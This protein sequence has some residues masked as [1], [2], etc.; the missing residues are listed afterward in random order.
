MP[1]SRTP[2]FCR[3]FAKFTIATG[4]ISCVLLCGR[5]FTD[6]I[7]GKLMAALDRLQ[8]WDRT[9]VV[10]TAITVPPGERGWWNKH[11]LYDRSCRAPLIICAPGV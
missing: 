2:R 8:L 9:V 10:F 4:W 11:T 6:A 1:R 5:F 7:V 3:E